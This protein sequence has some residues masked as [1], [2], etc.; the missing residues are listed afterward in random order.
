ML[1]ELY[2]VIII[3]SHII[4]GCMI[5][6]NSAQV[7]ISISPSIERGYLQSYSDMVI[8]CTWAPNE[9]RDGGA[10]DIGVL[11][12]TQSKNGYTHTLQSIFVHP[13]YSDLLAKEGM[14]NFL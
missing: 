12:W 8:E 10:A 3:T 14:L 11:V 6:S 2:F 5:Y 7:E 4:S 13:Q 9:M 1:K